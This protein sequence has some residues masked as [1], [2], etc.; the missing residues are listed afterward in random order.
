ME[1]NTLSSI[2][3]DAAKK[4]GWIMEN[5]PK[6]TNTIHTSKSGA[7]SVYP[8]EFRE[9]CGSKPRKTKN[10]HKAKRTRK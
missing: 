10:S 6:Y 5:D 3:A 4:L 1:K 7:Q 9:R 8:N 2:S